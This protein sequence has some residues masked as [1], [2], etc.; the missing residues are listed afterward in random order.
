MKMLSDTQLKQDLIK[1]A[2][3]TIAIIAIAAIFAVN[4]ALSTPTFVSL[5]FSMLFSPWVASLERRGVSRGLS[6]AIIFGGI[7]LVLGVLG[8]W[9]ASFQEEWLGFKE[10]APE[11]FQSAIHGLRKIE[12]NIKLRYSF[13]SGV[14]PTDSLLAWGQSTG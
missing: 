11:H 8:F 5:V 10:K 6:I 1:L 4:P 13:L 14:H 7:A 9:A 3:L 12:E 2:F